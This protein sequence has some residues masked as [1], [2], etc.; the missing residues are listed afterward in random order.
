M[1]T[2]VDPCRSEGR[3]EGAEFCK[4]G[5]KKPPQD[6]IFYPVFESRSNKMKTVCFVQVISF[7]HD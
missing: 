7:Q 5:L 4:I 6:Y 3:F 1:P 2:Q